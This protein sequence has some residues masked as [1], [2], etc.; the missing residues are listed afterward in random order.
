MMSRS[1]VC[2]FLALV[3]IVLPLFAAGASRGPLVGGWSPI[4]DLS[5]PHVKEIAEFAVAEYNKKS[6][7]ALELQSVVSGET[8]VVAGINYRLVVAAK[9]GSAS[10]NRYQAV[11]WEKAWE[12]SKNLTSFKPV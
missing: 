12:H 8:Q 5:D 1:S 9:D 4:K 7:A 10:A 2:L 11:V 6:K 3:A